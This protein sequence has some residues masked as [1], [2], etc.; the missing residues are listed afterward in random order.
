MNQAIAVLVAGDPGTGKTC[1][2]FEWPDIY[3]LDCEGN[4]KSGIDRNPGKRFWWDSPEKFD[5]GKPVPE[6]QRWERAKKLVEEAGKNQEVKVI[7]VDGFGRMCD[8]LQEFLIVQGS[9]AEA[10]LMV[11]GQKQM[12]RSLWNP[13]ARMMTE[14]VYSVR[15]LGKPFVMTTHLK[16][17]EN[18]LNS[19]KEQ[20]VNVQGRLMTDFPK[21]FTDFWQTLATP[22]AADAKKYPTGVR[23]YVRTAPTSRIALKTSFGL[24]AEFETRDPAFQD[25]IKRV[26]GQGQA[27]PAAGGA[28]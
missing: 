13:F 17:D 27:A 28:Q 1:G 24:P 4:L 7:A 12:T 22:V 11:G 6:A 19:V 18:E 23:Y 10:P 5:D 21:L 26:A 25:L 20:K 2:L 15:H 16:V 3:I 9:K 14:W 8:Y